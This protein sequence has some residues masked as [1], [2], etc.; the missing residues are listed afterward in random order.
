FPGGMPG[1]FPG[2]IP[3]VI[4][5]PGGVYPVP[6]WLDK[7]DQGTMTGKDFEGLKIIN[8]QRSNLKQQCPGTQI[9]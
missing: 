4:P 9:F 6:T 7:F 2:G 5:V 1:R 3:I 8:A